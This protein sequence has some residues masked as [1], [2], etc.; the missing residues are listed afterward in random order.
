MENDNALDAK[1]LAQILLIESMVSH[2]P[3]EKTIFAFVCRGL[4][5]IP[6]VTQVSYALYNVP[7]N[8]DHLIPIKIDNNHFGTLSFNLTSS[9]DFSCYLPYLDNLCH[10]LAVTLDL[11]QQRQSVLKAKEELELRVEQRTTELRLEVEERRRAQELALSNQLMAERYLSVS[12]SIIVELDTKACISVINQ[13]GCE[14]LGYKES[15][16]L[17]QEWFSLALPPT[18]SNEVR[19]I[20]YQFISGEIEPLNYYENEIITRNKELLT[21][22]WNNIL[23]FDSQGHCTGTLSSGH[24]V[25]KRIKAESQ[26]RQ[27]AF[28]DALTGLPNRRL[29]IDRLQQSMADSERNHTWKALFFLDLDDFK[30]L[31]DSLGHDQGDIVL[32]ETARRITSCLRDIDSV[33]RHGGDEFLILLGPLSSDVTEAVNSAE[34]V[35]K[36]ISYSLEAPY[37]LSGG[38]HQSTVSIGIALFQGQDSHV[39]TL[40]KHADVA[41]YQAKAAGKRRYRFFDP[42][43]QADIDK[44][45][46]L[47]TDLTNAIDNQEFQLYFQPQV[48]RDERCVGAEGLIRWNSPTR[49]MVSPMEFIPVAE[50]NRKI[51]SIGQWVLEE[52]CKQLLQ[53]QESSLTCDLTLAINVSAVQFNQQNFAEQVIE[54]VSRSG[55][56]PS[57]LKLEITESL[58]VQDIDKVIFKMAK[59]K[60]MAITFSIDDFGTGYSSLSYVK[61]LPVAQL[62]IDRSFVRDIIQDSS[63]AA[64]CKAI[65]AMSDSLGLKVI[66]EGVENSKQRQAL[67][68]AGCYYAQGYLFG[69]PMSANDFNEWLQLQNSCITSP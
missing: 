69:R 18:I 29:M 55:I 25:T 6:G 44:R 8:E 51:L 54:I 37:Q 24:D 12:E 48:D 52:A 56:D 19:D 39:D 46:N 13:R 61:R 30:D 15:E 5:S 65:I 27:L 57:K 41:M 49:G 45:R 23:L 40:F 67:L 26:A 28:Y 35:A 14:L 2:L 63:D 33:S 10:M 20:F 58:L 47:E 16:L 62:K 64:I 32:I 7:T 34:A 3:D 53:W 60:E 42:Q 9:T 22:S 68:S 43:M 38:V 31:N 17:G 36:K 50:A 11:R 4:E 21:I 1:V 59:L 66:A